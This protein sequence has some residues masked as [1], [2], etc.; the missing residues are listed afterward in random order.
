MWYFNSI[1]R[2]KLLWLPNE[3]NVLEIVNHK[4]MI[5]VFI[6][7]ISSKYLLFTKQRTNSNLSSNHYVEDL[8]QRVVN[9][10]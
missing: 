5:G 9:G 10:K 6:R 8:F 4:Y 2:A 3:I 1:N 7:L